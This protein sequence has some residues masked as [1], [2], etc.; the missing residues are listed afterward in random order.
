MKNINLADELQELGDVIIDQQ[1]VLFMN[2]ETGM[3]FLAINENNKDEDIKVLQANFEDVKLFGLECMNLDNPII[4][5]LK[6]LS[7]KDMG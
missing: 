2:N 3:Y 1:F 6:T 7:Y 4:N 5:G